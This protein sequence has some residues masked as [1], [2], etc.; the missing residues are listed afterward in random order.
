MLAVFPTAFVANHLGLDLDKDPIYRER[1]EKGLISSPKKHAEKQAPAATKLAVWMFV[2]A[3]ILIV[4]Y[5]TAI[6]DQVGLIT[7]P[8]LPRNEAIKSRMLACA[9]VITI[10]CRIPADEIPAT[11]V[12]W[13]GM[14]ACV[15]VMRVALFGTTLINAHI[16]STQQASGDIL[17]RTPGLLAMVL[18]FAIALL[19]SQAATANPHMPAAPAIGVPPLTAVA[20][21]APFSALFV[22]P[23]YPTLLA[24][25][26]M[27]HTGSTRIG[28][29][30]VNHPF[31]IPGALCIALSPALVFLFGSVV[32]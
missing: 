20:S 7:E 12:F 5:S 4:A 32:L 22:L 17:S 30:I 31:L 2:A 9:A 11:Q 24:A 8:A 26:E 16:D 23:T 28:R 15:C 6:S 1:L 27:D 13:A 25:V 18:F 3:I 29:Y 21:F 14:S 10:F 19:Y